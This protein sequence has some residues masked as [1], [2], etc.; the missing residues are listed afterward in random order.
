M[1]DAQLLFL[2]SDPNS[3]SR[4]DEK[5]LQNFVIGI[6]VGLKEFC[7][8]WSAMELILAIQIAVVYTFL[9]VSNQVCIICTR[10]PHNELSK[11]H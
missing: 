1:A 5:F 8:R 3:P 10:T 2:K 4:G 11:V 6:H 9:Y 7:S